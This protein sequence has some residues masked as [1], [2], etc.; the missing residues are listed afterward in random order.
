MRHFVYIIYSSQRDVYYKGYT[1]NPEHRLFEH[2]NGFSRYT[3]NR[4]PWLLVYLEEM[5]DKRSAL[6]REKQIKKYNQ[7]YIVK[8][9]GQP[10]NLVK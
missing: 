9:I 1:T 8:L 6:I 5:S 7:E 10:Q 3:K 4:G 2:N